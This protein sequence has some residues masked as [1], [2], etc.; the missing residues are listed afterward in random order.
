YN[1]YNVDGP[2]QEIV[3]DYEMKATG[4]IPVLG[5][6]EN[7][8]QIIDETS[9]YDPEKPW[10]GRDDR[11]YSSILYHGAMLQGRP[12]DISTHGQDNI[13]IGSIIRTN[14]FTNKYLDQNH[15]LITHESWTYRR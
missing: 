13:N 12:I 11:F 14:Y 10:E 3:D 2:L 5:Y 1:A 4:K 7:N 9:G 6:T 8:E 15:N